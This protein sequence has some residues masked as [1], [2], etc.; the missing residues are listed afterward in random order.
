M[1]RVVKLTLFPLLLAAVLAPAGLRHARGQREAGT[2]RGTQAA[3]AGIRRLVDVPARVGEG[4]LA[5]KNLTL[6]RVH[7]SAVLKGDI[8]NTSGGDLEGADFEV[9]AYDVR[10]EP[11]RG[12]EEK[13]VLSVNRLGA[14]ESVPLN[15]GYGVWLQGIAA[16]EV[17]GIELHEI[18][19]EPTASLAVKVIPF[20]GQAMFWKEYS[21]IE[22]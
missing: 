6:T 22:E 20:A 10:G 14:G 21:E 18:G 5:L 17:A 13:T 8:L 19:D 7:G 2:V 16:D 3:G 9:R 15:S 12:L 4:S 11:L 1:C